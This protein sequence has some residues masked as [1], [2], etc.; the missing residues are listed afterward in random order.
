MFNYALMKPDTWFKACYMNMVF[1]SL[2]VSD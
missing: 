2:V 1:R